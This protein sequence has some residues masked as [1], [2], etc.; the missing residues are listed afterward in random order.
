MKK[1][2]LFGALLF[3]AFS[4][5]NAYAQGCCDPCGCSP[6]DQPCGDCFC[7]YVHYEPYYYNTY[8]CVTEEVPTSRTC[9][10]YV[11]QYYQVPKCRYVPEY[12]SVTCCQYVPE[13]YEVPDCYYVQ[14]TICNPQC[15]YYPCYYWRHECCNTGCCGGFGG[16]Y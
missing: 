14:R 8:S 4:L 3:G 11:P 10:R 7:K 6:C 16:G 2:F 1:L 15:T 5:Q 13:Y 9:C 12:Y